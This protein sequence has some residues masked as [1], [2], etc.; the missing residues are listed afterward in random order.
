M[1]HTALHSYNEGLKQ[2][3]NDEFIERI[4]DQDIDYH[5]SRNHIQ[6][7]TVSNI[8]IKSETRQEIDDFLQKRREVVINI[9]KRE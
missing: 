8:I 7:E 2:Y 9:R 4:D 6:Y 3:I 5:F 1:M